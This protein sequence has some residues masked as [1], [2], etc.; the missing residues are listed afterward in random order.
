[1]TE[2]ANNAVTDLNPARVSL[3]FWKNYRQSN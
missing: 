2:F 3:G 1:M